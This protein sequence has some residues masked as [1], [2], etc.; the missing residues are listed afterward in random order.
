MEYLELIKKRKEHRVQ[1][2]TEQSIKKKMDY[3]APLVVDGLCFHLPEHKRSEL[4]S[5]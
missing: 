1:Q 2:K 5:K 4:V 3:V